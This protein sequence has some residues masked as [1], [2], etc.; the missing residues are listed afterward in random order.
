[1]FIAPFDPDPECPFKRSRLCAHRRRNRP[2]RVHELERLRRASAR[3]INDKAIEV[4][5]QWLA[6]RRTGGETE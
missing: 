4:L 3:H 1:M 6:E 2:V 5:R